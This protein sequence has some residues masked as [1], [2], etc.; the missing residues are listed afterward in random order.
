MLNTQFKEATANEIP[1]PGKKAN[2]ILSFLKQL[3]LKERDG[4]TL[5]KVDHLLK[6]ADEY[7]AKSVFDLCVKCLKDEP[8]SKEN[9]VRILYLAN[10]T[11]MAREEERLDIVRRDCYSLIKDMELEDIMG[12]E[13]FKSLDRDSSESVLVERAERLET[14]LKGVYPQLIGLAEFCIFLCLESSSYKSRITCCPQHFPSQNKANKGLLER[15]QTCP[16]CKTMIGQL[17]SLSKHSYFGSKGEHL[18]GGNCYFD[19]KLISI[20]QNFKNVFTPSP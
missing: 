2:E 12:K 13:D 19:Q 1:L 6:L 16:V 7:Q 5:D 10:S 18:Y 14:F 17:V 4:I 11:V 9:A 8:K 15:I 3:Y 20:I